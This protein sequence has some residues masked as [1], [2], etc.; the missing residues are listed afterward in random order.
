M[1]K[2][3][4]SL[5]NFAL[6]KLDGMEAQN[7]R[8]R[9]TV[10][11]PLGA[12]EVMQGGR[13]MINF[14]SNDYLGLNQHPLIKKASM[15]ATEKYGAGAGASRLVTGNHPLYQELEMRLARLKGSEDAVVF[16]SGFLANSGIIPALI[17][18]DDAV[19]HDELSHACIFYGARLT[20]GAHHVFRH[21]DMDHLRA[22]LEAE[23]HKHPHAMIATDGVFSM[24]GDLAPIGNLV[25]LAGTHDAWLMTDD[26]HGI[27]VVGG[28]RG[29]SFAHGARHAVPLQMGTLSKAIGGYGGY[30]CASHAVCELIRTRCRTFIYSTGLPPGAVAAS[31]AAL[32]LIEG[33]REFTERPLTLARTFTREL[34][35]PAAESPIVP[36]ILGDTDKTLAAAKLLA[37]ESFLIVPIRPPTVPEGTARLRITFSA[38]HKEADVIRLAKIIREKIIG[39]DVS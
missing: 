22:L 26:A 29:S 16:G 18:P 38:G 24:D 36:V 31:I 10:T 35:L 34:N 2:T 7:L 4:S 33:D 5:E 11:E 19:F 27:G 1:S 13:R 21:N 14:S 32:G 17:G 23:R 9:L 12:V 28:G 20:Q 25:E 6:A 30:L 37:D 15:E 3:P 8:R 39:E